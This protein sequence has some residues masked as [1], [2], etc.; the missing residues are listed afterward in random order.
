[1]LGE[2]AGERVVERRLEGGLAAGLQ[3]PAM[4]HP[5]PCAP[6]PARRRPRTAPPVRRRRETHYDPDH[7]AQPPPGRGGG[8]SP[9]PGDAGSPRPGRQSRREAHRR[10][11]PARARHAPVDGGHR[12]RVGAAPAARHP[13]LGADERPPAREPAD[14]RGAVDR[15]PAAR[16]RQRARRDQAARVAPAQPPAARGPDRRGPARGRQ[17]QRPEGARDR[18]RADRV[19]EGQPHRTPPAAQ[20]P[21]RRRRARRHR[22]AQPPRPHRAGRRRHRPAGRGRR[23]AAGQ[24]PA[25]AGAQDRQDRGRAEGAQDREDARHRARRRRRAADGRR[26][27]AVDRPPAHRRGVR[28]LHPLRR[29]RGAGVRRVGGD[30]AVNALAEA[31]NARPAVKAVFI[32][33]DVAAHRRGVGLDRVRPLPGHGRVAGRLRAARDGACGA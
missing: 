11:H 30:A 25:A 24:P 26:H 17:P 2:R 20:G 5:R 23:S 13:E 16:L 10:G 1:M 8:A 9:V 12:R 15:H 18:R 22:H 7:D 32:D 21:Q 4:S 14:P 6:A 3:P 28:R 27:R 31:P 19:G 33:R 29:R